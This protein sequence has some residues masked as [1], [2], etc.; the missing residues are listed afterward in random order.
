MKV[1]RKLKNLAYDFACDWCYEWGNSSFLKVAEVSI[2]HTSANRLK[3]TAK[4]FAVDDSTGDLQLTSSVYELSMEQLENSSSP[5]GDRDSPDADFIDGDM[6]IIDLLR[7]DFSEVKHLPRSI[8]IDATDELSDDAVEMIVEECF[9]GQEDDF[10]FEIPNLHPA[11]RRVIRKLCWERVAQRRREERE[12]KR[13]NRQFEL[14]ITANKEIPIKIGKKATGL[15][16]IMGAGIGIFNGMS[17]QLSPSHMGRATR[18]AEWLDSKRSEGCAIYPASG[19]F[20]GEEATGPLVVAV[21][22]IS[23]E[24]VTDRAKYTATGLALFIG[25]NRVV[26]VTLDRN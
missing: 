11:V 8:V 1:T 2:I 3:I 6:E 26:K 5:E 4:V 22:D 21:C 19:L 14:V 7:A 17:Q 9:E 12:L 15:H 10:S 20:Q 25:P 24:E 16:A 23:E 18:F 13:R